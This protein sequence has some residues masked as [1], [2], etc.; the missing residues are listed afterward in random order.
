[1][2][3]PA[4]SKISPG[5]ARVL[6]A[7]LRRGEFTAEQLSAETGIKPTTV[8]TILNRYWRFFDSATRSGSGQRGGQSKNRLVLP[9][10]RGE[11]A[12][13]VMPHTRSTPLGYGDCAEV[14]DS[15]GQ[16][17]KYS[18]PADVWHLVDGHL[19]PGAVCARSAR[20]WQRL[21]ADF[22]PLVMPPA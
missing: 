14:A 4:V 8:R 22:G 16:R 15:R 7:A 12:A 10:R 3:D 9:S 1:M 2:S 19:G 17:W 18:E 11:L 21:D 5:A 13:L 6:G 20:S